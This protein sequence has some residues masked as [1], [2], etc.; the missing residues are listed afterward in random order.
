MCIRDRFRKE[1]SYANFLNLA[2]RLIIEPI[3]IV[4]VASFGYFLVNTKNAQN[5][6]PIIGALTFCGVRLLP[7]AQ[8]IYE[9]ITLPKIARS[10]LVNILSILENPPLER[11]LQFK[12]NNSL[13]LKNKIELKGVTY[14]Y[15]SKDSFI[16]KDLNLSINTGQKIGII[17]RTGSGKSTLICL[18]Y[19]SDAAD[20]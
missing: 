17:G 11:T 3:A 8:R 7:F 4:L 9:G 6:I 14:A 15:S 16:L 5:V 12:N 19:T 20:E 10:R 2:P 1:E 13:V 18:L